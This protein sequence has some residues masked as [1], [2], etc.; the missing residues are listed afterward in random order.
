VGSD[1]LGTITGQQGD[2]WTSSNDGD[3]AEHQKQK[4]LRCA[5]CSQER[6]LSSVSRPVV[7]WRLSPEI[8]RASLAQDS[9]S[10]RVAVRQILKYSWAN[11]AMAIQRGNAMTVLAGYAS[12]VLRVGAMERIV[13]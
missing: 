9:S 1:P 12:A 10:C 4:K 2:G 6:L 11:V 13:L 5:R 7:V 3:T 8:L